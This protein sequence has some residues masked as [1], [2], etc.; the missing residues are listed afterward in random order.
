MAPQRL[1]T[2]ESAPG[3]GMGSEP[4]THKMWYAGAGLTFRGTR[5]ESRNRRRHAKPRS[6]SP[7]SARREVEGK[8][9]ALQALEI[10]RNAEGIP[11]RRLRARAPLDLAE[12]GPLGSGAE[13]LQKVAEKGA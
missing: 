5:E 3:N 8:F 13:S 10:P 9:S 11:S 7:N 1:E 12:P 4:R 6:F 2:I